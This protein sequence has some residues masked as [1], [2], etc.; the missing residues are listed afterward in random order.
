MLI[1]MTEDGNRV[2]NVLLV[3]DPIPIKRYSVLAFAKYDVS[4][5]KSGE[6]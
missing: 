4:P 5:E 3:T 6:F 2:Y 1:F